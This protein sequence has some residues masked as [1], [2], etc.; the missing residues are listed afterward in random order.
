M[1]DAM[2][3]GTRALLAYVRDTLAEALAVKSVRT[4][5]IDYEVD[6]T[7]A[8]VAFFNGGSI[9]SVRSTWQKAIKG[10][11]RDVYVEGMA[12]GK[13]PADEFDADDQDAV[14]TWIG[15]QLGYVD[16][17]VDAVKEAGAAEGDARTGAQQ[18]IL[19]RVTLWVAALKDLG[20]LGRI[21]ALEGEL[22]QWELGD[23]EEHCADCLANSRLKPKRLKWWRDNE[24]LPRA[25]DLACGGFNCDCGLRSVRTGRWL[26]P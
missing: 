19:N 1:T 22:A 17:F 11:A 3:R 5:A 8:V 23:T 15:E 9:R 26:Y 6:L 14:D 7:E 21:R 24:R 12:E 13:M 16:G 18:G 2:P 4:V 20:G 25:H 10:Y